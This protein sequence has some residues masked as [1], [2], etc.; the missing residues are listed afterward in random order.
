MYKSVK[1]SA[2][3]ISGNVINQILYLETPVNNSS[4]VD[5]CCT[6]G[7][8]NSLNMALFFGVSCCT[9]RLINP[10]SA[11][12]KF[13]RKNLTSVDY[14][15]QNLT[16]IDVRFW[17]LKSIAALQTHNISRGGLGEL[18]HRESWATPDITVTWSIMTR[19]CRLTNKWYITYCLCGLTTPNASPI[20]IHE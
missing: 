2:C 5:K 14:R 10:V 16:S 18:G 1:F 6:A 7:L 20:E 15:R 12:I 13:W 3:P 17:R 9:I 8:G 19:C 4:H 11:R